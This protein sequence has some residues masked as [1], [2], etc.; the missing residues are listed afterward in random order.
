MRS[1]SS[2]AGQKELT[3]TGAARRAQIVAG[4]IDT[5]AEVGY[6]QASLVRIAQRV[7]I[8]KGVIAYHFDS[9]EDLVKEVA[10]EVLSKAR[11]YMVPRINAASDG[12]EKLRAYIESNIGFMAEHRSD[13]IAIAEIARGARETTGKRTFDASSLEA[14]TAA[15]A[16]LLV[17]FQA[18]GELRGDF[19][20]RVMAETIRAA[21]DA[22][23]RRMAANPDL[24]V[25]LYRR[26]LANLFDLAT[27]S[28][29][30]RTGRRRR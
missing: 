25:D 27:R 5:I 9:K 18:T 24:D 12:R 19:D 26:D 8:S 29:A 3:F 11:D 15:L 6:G 4:A 23:P 28:E 2:P 22:V 20:A 10:A 14:G 16:E 21:I 7:G 13:M 17:S 30:P 1:D